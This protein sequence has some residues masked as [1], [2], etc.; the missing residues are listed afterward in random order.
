MRLTIFL[1]LLPLLVKAQ[2]I[3]DFWKTLEPRL[4]NNTFFYSLQVNSQGGIYL[5]TNKGIVRSTDEGRSWASLNV[6]P[7]PFFHL[8]VSGDSIYG[9]SDSGIIY[10]S[11]NGGESWHSSQLQQVDGVTD[12]LVLANGDVLV[13]TGYL[14]VANDVGYFRGNGLFKSV[15]DGHTWRKVELGRAQD[16]YI[17]HLAQGSLGRI[18]A[19]LNEYTSADGALLYSAD[20]GENWQ[21]LPDPLFDWGGEDGLGT[22]SIVQVTSLEVDRQ[23]NIRISLLGASGRVATSL[24]LS[25]SFQGAVNGEEWNHHHLVSFGYPWLYLESHNS[26]FASNGDSYAFRFGTSLNLSG[27]SYSKQGLGFEK[28]HINPLVIDGVAQFNYCVFAESPTGRVYLIQQLDRTL[29]YTDESVKQ[30]VLGVDKGTAIAIYPNPASQYV[31]VR[32][33]PSVTQVQIDIF[34]SDGCQVYNGT[35]TTGGQT[36]VPLNGVLPGIY[37]VTVA[38]DRW[39]ETHRLVVE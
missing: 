22:T 16:Q 21:P 28:K 38:T 6:D 23:D 12:I 17:S 37:F 2:L 34:S 11:L 7:M 29:Y 24:N 26:F 36:E 14:E 20:H 8:V 39:K 9:V 33:A 19:S 4:G 13:A 25:S 32:L 18:Y 15:D 1:L 27:V 5:G 3:G 10:V 35:F 31:S 30:P